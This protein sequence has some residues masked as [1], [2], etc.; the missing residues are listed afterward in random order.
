MARNTGENISATPFS[1]HQCRYR[2]LK[3]D[4]IRPS[5][6]RCVR[7]GDACGYPQVRRANVG[8][9]KRVHELETKLDQLERLARGVE[10]P[11]AA[12]EVT[13]QQGAFDDSRDFIINTETFNSESTSATPEPSQSHSQADNYFAELVSVGLFEQ[14]PSIELVTFLVNSYFEKWHYAAPMFQQDRYMMSLYLP[15][16][17]RPPM[18][19]QYIIMALGADIVKTHRQLAIPFYQRA[20]AYIQS[21]EMRGEGQFFA[22]LAH[23]QAWSL[24]ANFEAQQ[25]F[26]A[27]SSM[28]LCRAIRTAQML[29]LHHIDRDS[30][31]SLPL[32]APPAD[33]VEAEERRRTW[34]VIYCS[35]R[36]VCG[37]TGWPAMID[38]RDLHTRLPASENAFETG[39][40]EPTSYL[41]SVLHQEGQGFSPFAGRVLATSLFY[42]TFQHSTQLPRNGVC[43][44]VDISLYWK[45]HH[46]I[47]NDLV[48]LLQGLPGDLQLPCKIRCQNA[49]FVNIIIQ[50]SIICLHRGVLSSTQRLGLSEQTIRQSRGRL[51]AAAEELLNIF[52]MMPDVNQALKNPMLT[53]SV[54]TASLV[55]LDQP[56]SADPHYQRQDSL[57]FILR[58]MM[59][60]AK[61]WDNPVTGSMAA[62]LASDMR[63]RGID[64]PAVEKAKEM[65]LQRSLVPI[66]AKG[67]SQSSNFLFQLTSP[68][69]GSTLSS[70]SDNL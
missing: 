28:S 14:Q 63:Q 24:I 48:A 31:E 16:H 67:D 19:L 58:I 13:E 66:F 3:C 15:P 57:N 44:D 59:L 17:M 43:S 33:W 36:L 7:I 61:T 5:C 8:R 27:Q 38:E 62:Q 37:S 20:R 69:S 11:K 10:Q 30:M 35:D 46:E 4:R 65:P 54:Y 2:K 26:F 9:R 32:L 70:T 34:W 42:Q 40:E 41:T 47:D 18:C 55:F 53:F 6:G 21:D 56:V 45:R 39:S 60:A 1:C 68:N 29:G 22:T 52:R 49:T 50:T 23:A 25:L 51:I 64:S 12:Q